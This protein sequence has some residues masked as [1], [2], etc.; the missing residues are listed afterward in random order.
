MKLF[1]LSACFESNDGVDAFVDEGMMRSFTV[2]ETDWMRAVQHVLQEM[3]R[4][5]T[6]GTYK[7]FDPAR[8]DLNVCITGHEIL[9]EVGILKNSGTMI[10]EE[11]PAD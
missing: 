6:D 11:F 3:R 8:T 2:R 4:W 5:K 10:V 9:G 1:S 7:T